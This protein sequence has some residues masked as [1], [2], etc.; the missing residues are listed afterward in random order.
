MLGR[1]DGLDDG[2]QVVDVGEGFDAKDN[3]IV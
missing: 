3:V 1:N 2:C